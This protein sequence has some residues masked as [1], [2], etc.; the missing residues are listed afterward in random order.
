VEITIIVSGIVLGIALITG[1]A[2]FFVN[3]S[4]PRT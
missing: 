2:I 1:V 4:N 3:K